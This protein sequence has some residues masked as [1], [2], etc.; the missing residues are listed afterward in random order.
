MGLDLL[1]IKVQSIEVLAGL[2]KYQKSNYKYEWTYVQGGEHHYMYLDPSGLEAQPT[3]VVLLPIFDRLNNR[4]NSPDDMKLKLSFWQNKFTYYLTDDISLVGEYNMIKAGLG[5]GCVDANIIY[6]KDDYGNTVDVVLGNGVARCSGDSQE[7]EDLYVNI[8]YKQKDNK[9][10]VFWR[11]SNR[12]DYSLSYKNSI[13]ALTLTTGQGAADDIIKQQLAFGN[14]YEVNQ[15]LSYKLTEVSSL[16]FW[17]NRKFYRPAE[18]LHFVNA[19]SNDD[20]KTDS[21]D[22]LQDHQTSNSVGFSFS[23]SF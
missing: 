2:G 13:S 5:P 19:Q 22:W 15:S 4:M 17:Y 8:R 10:S 16:S 6:P 1:P 7:G 23:M 18:T 9:Y 20:I 3:F 12:A 11:T 14:S 21:T